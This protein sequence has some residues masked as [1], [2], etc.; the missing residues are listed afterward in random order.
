AAVAA[1]FRAYTV[2]E[3]V[4]PVA[5]V[6]NAAGTSSHATRSGPRV[7]AAHG[8]LTLL[9]LFVS[10]TALSAS[11]FA[12][13][14]YVPAALAGRVRVVDPVFVVNGPSAGMARLPSSTALPSSV[15]P[16]T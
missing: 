2:T 1:S 12:M 8:P 5:G 6:A 4:A 11:A 13:I 15:V 9:S 16:V 14:R 10:A 7:N 3:I